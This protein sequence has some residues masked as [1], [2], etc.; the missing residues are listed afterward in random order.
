MSE[1]PPTVISY[2]LLAPAELEVIRPLWEQ[3]NQLH[4]AFPT[5]FAAEIAARTFDPRLLAFREKATAGRL[6]VEIARPAPGAAPVAY[7]VTSLS[8]EGAGEVDSLFVAPGH[9]RRGVASALL[10]SA[11]DWLRAAGA[12]SQRVVVLQANDEAI[13]FYRRFGFAPRNLELERT[14]PF[15]ATDLGA[16]RG[17]AGKSVH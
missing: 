10:R 7:C 16:A 1:E 9:R 2:H 14:S 6:R 11:L 12:K 15:F 5:P 13:A 3:L 8:A 17:N 4:A